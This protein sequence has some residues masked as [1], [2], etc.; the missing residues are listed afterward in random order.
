MNMCQELTIY[1]EENTSP[2]V[3]QIYNTNKKIIDK[4][5]KYYSMTNNI[6]KE[7]AIQEIKLTIYNVLKK[8]K[9]NK[10]F[11]AYLLKS[12]DNTL[13][14]YIRKINTKKTLKT[15][16]L[17]ESKEYEDNRYNPEKVV[18]KELIYKEI[19]TKI[20][21]KLTWKEELIFTLKEQNFTTKEISSIT[22]MSMS[23]IYNLLTKIKSKSIKYL[24]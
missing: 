1:K 3:E 21:S 18:I 17:E 14:N 15:I 4:R 16:S 9:G 8:Y 12:I 24:S 10:N 11:K 23:T 5:I 6:S 7:E 20:I 19:R 13:L 2:L 22:D